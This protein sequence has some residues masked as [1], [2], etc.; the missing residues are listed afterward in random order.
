MHTL[1]RTGAISA[2]ELSASIRDYIVIDVRHL[3]AWQA[4]HVPGSIPLEIDTVSTTWTELDPW[5]PI[6]VVADDMATAEIAVAQLRD[7]GRDTVVL[8][9]GHAAWVAAAGCIVR[10]SQTRIS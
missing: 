3:D 9:G 7:R 2:T 4:G 5:V 8:E 1:R 6:V 10:C